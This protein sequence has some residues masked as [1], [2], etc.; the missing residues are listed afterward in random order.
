[1]CES[2]LIFNDKIHFFNCVVVTSQDSKPALVDGFQPAEVECTQ[3]RTSG[4]RFSAEAQLRSKVLL[5][6]LHG[7]L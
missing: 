1:M 6:Q 4:L 2:V 7:T 5:V 3:D